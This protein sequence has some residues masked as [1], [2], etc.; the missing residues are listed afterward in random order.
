MIL[1]VGSCV[2]DLFLSIQDQTHIKTTGDKI[3]FLLGDKIPVNITATSL[4]G[5]AANVSVGLQRLAAPVSFF[6]WLGGDIFSKEIRETLGKE[7]IEIIAQQNDDQPSSVSFILDASNDRIIFSHHQ[8]R[9]H[10]FNYSDRS[11]PDFVYLTS[12]GRNWQKMYKKVLELVKSNGIP[13]GFTPGSSQLEEKTDIFFEVLQNSKILFVNCQEAKKILDWKSL[14]WQDAKDI[15]VKIKSLG[16]QTVSVTDGK[17]GAYLLD[18]NNNF[19][20]TKPYLPKNGM[21]NIVDKTGAGD[22]YTSGFLTGLLE[23]KSMEECMK[24]GSINAYF[25]MQKIGAQKG[26]LK[27]DEMN[28]A[29]SEN[30][31]HD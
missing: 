8:V 12:C 15:L 11:L 14:K 26:L 6:T 24:M 17:N 30:T 10:D 28:K 27:R 3:E 5:N 31:K 22:A 2:I 21:K 29:V 9:D 4:G 13:L 1:T 23:D 20:F 19:Y 16:P 18:Q 25:V 7:R